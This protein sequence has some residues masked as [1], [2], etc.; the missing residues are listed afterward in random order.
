MDVHHLKKIV[1]IPF[2]V[3]VRVFATDVIQFVQDVIKLWVVVVQN[4]N[5]LLVVAFP[6]PML[7]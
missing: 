2:V 5:K 7:R 3:V 6:I 4:M 1:L